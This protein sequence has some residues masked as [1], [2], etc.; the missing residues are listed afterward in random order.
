MGNSERAGLLTVNDALI[1]EAKPGLSTWFAENVIDPAMNAGP[2]GIYNTAAQF[3]D[4]P[5][6]HLKVAETK[7]FSFDWFVQGVSSGVGSALPFMLCAA[8]SGAVM[9]STN[10]ALAGTKAG[11]FLNPLLKSEIAASVAGAGLYGGLQKPHEEQTRLGNALG[12]SAGFMV[13]HY[14]NSL[15]RGLPFGGKALAYP[16]TG[17]AGGATMAEV[18]SLASSGKLASGEQAMQSAVQGMAMNIVMPIVQER[19]IGKPAQRIQDCETPPR[20]IEKVEVKLFE[21]SGARNITDIAR[22]SRAYSEWMQEN[23]AQYPTA[24][25]FAKLAPEQIAQRGFLHPQLSDAEL[26]DLFEA[27]KRR[28]LPNPDVVAS[29]VGKAVADM[30]MAASSGDLIFGEWN[31]EFLSGDKAK[32]FKDTY[33]QVVPR[34]HLMFVEEA[35][36][37]GLEQIAKDNGYNYA[38]S[39]ANSRGQAVGFLVN[40]RLKVLGTATYESVAEVQNIP[41]LRPAFRIN[42][43]DTASGEEMSAVVVHLKSMRGG[44]AATA[45]V[46]FQQTTRL[47]AALEPEFK[48]IIAGD[49]NTFLGKTSELEPLYKAGFKLLS[50]QDNTSTQVMGGRLDGYLYKGISGLS[51][52]EVR[53]FFR[54]PKI[55]RGLSD[56]GLLTTTLSPEKK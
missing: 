14:G 28:P 29:E 9:R 8:G 23:K 17:L 47:A 46:R 33:K 1:G 20:P 34:H 39:R 3:V 13:F 45:A 49:W 10:L 53:S 24:E 31:M 51:E 48:G 56:H 15:A 36:A 50:P 55:T 7:S 54:N 6:L 25:E 41:D 19:I 27:S 12:A 11:A 37:A 40:P 2:L 22:L 43:Q 26:F 16:L 52:Q 18:S 38:I 4:L 30:P 44:P 32:F 35:D 21:P 42:L 5:E